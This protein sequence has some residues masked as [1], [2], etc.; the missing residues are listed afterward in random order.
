M[1]FGLEVLDTL[2]NVLLNTSIPVYKFLSVSSYTIPASGGNTIFLAP[3]LTTDGSTDVFLK[4]SV[5]LSQRVNGNY[6]VSPLLISK[7]EGSVTLRN[8]AVCATDIDIF[9]VSK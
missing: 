2:G 5:S 4:Y 6:A 7:N 1:I 8:Y 9:V 3:G